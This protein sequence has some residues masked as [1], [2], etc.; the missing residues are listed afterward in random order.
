M[1][2]WSLNQITNEEKENI[3]SQHREIYNGYRTVQSNPSNTQPLYV[4]DFAKDKDGAVMSNKGNIKKYTN[5]GI[6]EQKEELNCSECGGM[7]KEG[8]CVECGWKGEVGEM[9]EDDVIYKTGKLS[10]IYNVEDL[11]DSE[12]DY[13]EGGGN[14]FGTF[15]KMRHMKEQEELDEINP[16]ALKKG[17]KYK[18]DIPSYEDEIEY[19]DE[20]EDKAGGEKM[21]KFKGRK[22]D[23]H[24][25]SKGSIEKFLRDLEEQGVTG[26]GNSP[27][28]SISN[29]KSAYDFKSS[30][31]IY[32]YPT[33][34]ELEE[35]HLGAYDAMESAWNEDEIEEANDVSGVQGVY[36]DMEPAYD[37]DSEGPGKAGPYQRSSWAGTV[38]DEPSDDD[39][40]WEKDLDQD[41]LD[42]DVEKFNPEDK[43]WEDITRYTGEDEFANL[44]DE[45]L[46]ESVKNQKTKIQE[47][48]KRMK[49]IK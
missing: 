12:F 33:E 2:I 3:L 46:A 35:N 24:L 42:L 39:M 45:D 34:G 19:S 44:V 37:F 43:S 9:K 30:G 10:D 5:V 20:Y 23:T 48:F 7:V 47:M 16:E 18:F 31:P 13:V 17:K 25:V 8:E 38:N 22:D 26:G 1:K 36:G 29:V 15:E 28:T 41:E 40:Y 32:A 6:N 21:Y 14:K 11:G 49:V 27:D 4:Q